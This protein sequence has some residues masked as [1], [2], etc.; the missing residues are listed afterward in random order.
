ML[1]ISSALAAS[2][3]R[4]KES[5]PIVPFF[6]QLFL[7]GFKWSASD[8]SALPHG[9]MQI[10][11]TPQ[12]LTPD[13]GEMQTD[14]AATHDNSDAPSGTSTKLLHRLIDAKADEVD[15]HLDWK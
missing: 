1:Q 13:Q 3:E 4:S 8:I 6:K 14:E 7:G 2:H 12:A 10:S 11:T 5:D 9:N 15:S